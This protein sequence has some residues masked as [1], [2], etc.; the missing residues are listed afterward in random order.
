MDTKDRSISGVLLKREGHRAT[1]AMARWS[2]KYVTFTVTKGSGKS[3]KSQAVLRYFNVT[4]A[5]AAAGQKP[6]KELSMDSSFLC[7]DAPNMKFEV[8]TPRGYTIIFKCSSSEELEQWVSR[9]EPPNYRDRLVAFYNER[10]PKKVSEVGTHPS[11]FRAS[12]TA[13]TN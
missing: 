7:I 9:V 11:C 2:R 8:R 4:S 1:L 5:E 13:P 6:R 12:A 10:N 3:G